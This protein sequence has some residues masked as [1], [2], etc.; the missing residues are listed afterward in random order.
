MV[1]PTKGS[2]LFLGM[3]QTRTRCPEEEQFQNGQQRNQILPDALLRLSRN[4]GSE[5]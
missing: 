3:F 2:E 1:L 4:K 5:Q